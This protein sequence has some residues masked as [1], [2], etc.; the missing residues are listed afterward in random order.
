MHLYDEVEDVGVRIASA[1]SS[2]AHQFKVHAPS[3][4]T[5]IWATFLLPADSAIPLD[6]DWGLRWTLDDNDDN[7]QDFSLAEVTQ[8]VSVYCDDPPA[9]LSHAGPRY[10]T[11]AIAAVD[12]LGNPASALTALHSAHGQLRV[13][14]RLEDGGYREVAFSLAGAAAAIDKVLA[15]YEASQ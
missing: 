9:A 11:F 6:T 13:T 10:I 14:Y 15:L 8:A 2:D 5:R 1:S 3:H 12:N 7:N 4:E